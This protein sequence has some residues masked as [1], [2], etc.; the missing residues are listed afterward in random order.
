MEVN[1]EEEQTPSVHILKFKL[2]ENFTDLG[3]NIASR[4]DK[5]LSTNYEPVMESVAQSIDRWMS[6]PISRIGRKN[7]RKINILPKFVYLFQ[8]I[9][10]AP[11]TYLFSRMRKPFTKISPIDRGGLKCPNLQ[12]YYWATQLRTIMFYFSTDSP[13]WMDMELSSFKIPLHLYQHSAGMK[14]LRKH[15]L[16]PMLSNMI[17][18]WFDVKKNIYVYIGPSIWFRSNLGK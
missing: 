8:N 13:V 5:I 10:L 11:P 18:V 12:W 4:L 2:S 17:K 16:N 6:L 14:Y 1:K 3:I 15:T 7:I 9:P